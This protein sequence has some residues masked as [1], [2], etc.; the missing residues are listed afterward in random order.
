MYNIKLAGNLSLSINNNNL[1]KKNK[2]FSLDIRSHHKC[3]YEM[4]LKAAM[5]LREVY[6]LLC[7]R[8][9]LIAQR[10]RDSSCEYFYS[11]LAV[12]SWHH[13]VVTSRY[14]LGFPGNATSSA[15]ANAVEHYYVLFKSA[16]HFGFL[17]SKPCF[18]QKPVP[19]NSCYS[20]ANQ[21]WISS[22]LTDRCDQRLVSAPSIHPPLNPRL[23]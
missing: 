14:I 2:Q 3:W 21:Q 10:G 9:V 8:H 23:N 15:N 6:N 17:P 13:P 20:D 12:R 19:L 22:F 16:F 4:I 1:W 11:S 7:V 5:R 18:S